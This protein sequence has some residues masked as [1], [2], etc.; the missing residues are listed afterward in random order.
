[1]ADIPPRVA[2]RNFLLLS[3]SIKAPFINPE[4]IVK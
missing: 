3:I 1:M 2:T 4:I